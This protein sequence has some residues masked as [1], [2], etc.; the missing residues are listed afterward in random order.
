[1]SFPKFYFNLPAMPDVAAVD[2]AATKLGAH[3]VGG[4]RGF[5]GLRANVE[6]D[7]SVAELLDRAA[8]QVELR[9]CALEAI[10]D[11]WESNS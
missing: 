8:M 6:I 10:A 1:M 9:G 3:R 11:G 4:Y 5:D 7:Q 2:A